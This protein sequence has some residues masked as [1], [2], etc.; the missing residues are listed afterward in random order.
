[1]WITKCS[2][3]N[4][5]FEKPDRWRIKRKLVGFYTISVDLFHQSSSPYLE[6]NPLPLIYFTMCIILRQLSW[7][8]FT[9]AKF[10]KE[11]TMTWGKI[12]IKIKR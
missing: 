6:L 10:K 9:N 11:Q 3:H 5:K 4:K 2:I 1:M 7:H 8:N 12:K